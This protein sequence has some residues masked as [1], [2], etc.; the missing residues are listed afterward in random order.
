M[1]E[2]PRAWSCLADDGCW[3]ERGEEG[4]EVNCLHSS[5]TAQPFPWKAMIYN[6]ALLG[7]V[8]NGM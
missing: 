2:Q 1:R 4:A 3:L 7:N 8:E 6:P 5:S